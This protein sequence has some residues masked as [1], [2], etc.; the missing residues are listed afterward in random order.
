MHRALAAGVLAAGLVLSGAVLQSAAACGVVG[1]TCPPG[2]GDTPTESGNTI[3]VRVTGSFVRSG[4]GGTGGST[5]VTVPTP[6][7]YIASFSGKEYYD[8]VKSGKAAFEW[9]HFSH[10]N[11]P[12][13]PTPGYESHKD[14]TAGH[15]YGGMCSSATFGSNLDAFFAFAND[16]FAKHG[17]VWVPAGGQPPVPPVPPQVLL[18]AA[19]KAMT[20]PEPTFDWN[21]K[22]Q[23]AGAS[24]VNLDT[25]FWLDD[26]VATGSVTAT[27]GTNSVTVTAT[28]ESVSFSSPTAGGVDCNDGGTAWS[29]GAT[30]ACT[31]SFQH[32]S[33]AAGA[34]VTSRAHWGL[35]WTSNGAPQGALAPVDAT[36]VD[37][38][39]V[40]EVQGLVNS[41]G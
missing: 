38:V 10:G 7:S 14:D 30:S 13:Q 12:F 15:Y 23:G 11:G 19:Q 33:D 40:I 36:Q 2:G 32:A 5:T 39:R 8:W 31:L 9:Y 17:D 3:T 22:A 18:A 29:R 26:G 27:A 28:R 24:L 20:L 21:P 35:S 41:V 4:S 6:C 34:P 25:W 37:N 16:W 1:G